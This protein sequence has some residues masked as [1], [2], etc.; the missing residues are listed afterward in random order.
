MIYN[1]L[2]KSVFSIEQKVWEINW[3]KMFVPEEYFLLGFQTCEKDFEGRREGKGLSVML[4][5]HYYSVQI[6][7][8]KISKMPL[9]TG[10][11]K[12]D[13]NCA[14]FHKVGTIFVKGLNSL[15]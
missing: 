14:R 7:P 2:F 4:M 1:C 15:I 3:I 10:D 13:T 9:N 6:A 12:N 5:A 8:E 11:D